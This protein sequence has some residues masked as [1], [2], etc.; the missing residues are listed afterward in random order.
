MDGLFFI[1]EG[2]EFQQRGIMDFIE[3]GSERT[4]NMSFF[5]D[6]VL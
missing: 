3:R 4:I 2:N 6:R 1:A 5:V